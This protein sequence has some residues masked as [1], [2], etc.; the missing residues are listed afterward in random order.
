MNIVGIDGLTPE[1]VHGELQSGARF[2]VYQYCIS[3]LIMT[4][5]RSSDIHFIRPGE[6]RVAKGTGFTLLSLVA[7]WWGFPWGPIYTIGSLVTNLGGGKDVTA[8]VAHAMFAPQPQQYYA[9]PVPPGAWPP[10]P[11]PPPS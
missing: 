11:G 7:G 4:F 9:P 2:V 3:I 8:E 5:R 10:P 1:Q 6:S